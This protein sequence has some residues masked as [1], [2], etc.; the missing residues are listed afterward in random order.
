MNLILYFQPTG[1]M[2]SSVLYSS[3]EDVHIVSRW[4]AGQKFCIRITIP[5]GSLLMQVCNNVC[6]FSKIQTFYISLMVLAMFSHFESQFQENSVWFLGSRGIYLYMYLKFLLS[7]LFYILD[8]LECPSWYRFT[9]VKNYSELISLFCK[10][11]HGIYLSM[12]CAI[13]FKCKIHHG[14]LLFFIWWHKWNYICQYHKP[15]TSCKW[16]SQVVIKK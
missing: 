9:L 2:D 14:S 3:I 5:D 10:D 7:W 16:K 12:T 11:L 6:S 4:N 1:M 13:C 8:P 15:N